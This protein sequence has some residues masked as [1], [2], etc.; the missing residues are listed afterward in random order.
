MPANPT[1][2]EKANVDLAS[3]LKPLLGDAFQVDAETS[4]RADRKLPDI[5]ITYKRSGLQIVLEAKYD[6]FDEAVKAAQKRWHELS[7]P[8][9]VVGAVSYSPS[10]KKNGFESAVRNGDSIDFALSGEQYQDMHALKRRGEIY[11]LAHA[12]RRPY[13]V[14]SRD[15]DAVEKAVDNIKGALAVFVGGVKNN[16]GQAMELA[17]ILQASFNGEKE[18]EVLEQSAKMAGLIL[19]G[20]VLFQLALSKEDA[21][22]SAPNVVLEEEGVTGLDAHWDYILNEINYAAIFRIAR[23]ICAQNI[24]VDLVKQLVGVAHEVEH[25]AHDGVDLMGRIYHRLLADAKT[26]GAFYTTIPAATMMAGLVLNTDDWTDTDWSDAESVGKFRIA[27]PAC[28]SGTLLTAAAWQLLDNFSR[29]HF[30]KHG[31]R[32]GGEKRDDPRAHLCRLLLEESIWGYDILETATHLTAATLGMISPQT[33]F[34]KARIYRA[35][36]GETKLGTA[37]GSLEMLK[38]TKPIFRRDVQIESRD[39]SAQD[40]SRDESEPAESGEDD[41]VPPLHVCIMNP[42]FVRGTAGH[43]S[44]AFLPKNEQKS[45]RRLVKNLG[46]EHNF[47]PDG[48][49]PAFIALAC[50]KRM[51][52]EFI[53]KGGR[54]AVILPATAAVGMG[55]AWKLMRKKIEDDFDLEAL[56]VSREQGRVNFSED[57]MLQECILIAR[58]R[59]D[60]EKPQKTAMFVVLHKNPATIDVALATVQ[61]ILRAKQGDESLGDLRFEAASTLM[62]GEGYIGQYARLPWHGKKAWRGLSFANIHLAFAAETFSESGNLAPFVARGSVPLV[63]LQEIATVGSNRMHKYTKDPDVKKRYVRLSKTVTD[64]PGYYPGHHRGKP[65]FGKK[66]CRKFPNHR[67]ATGCR[68]R[69]KS[70]GRR[71]S[72]HRPGESCCVKVSAF[73]QCAA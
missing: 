40:G 63:P 41:S 45:V 57:T 72:L 68:C 50:L 38:R 20:A 27:D 2:E 9:S 59:N 70:S 34:K 47:V 61:A 31:G 32:I 1:R 5:V 54:L 25:L 17:K 10:F 24:P 71:V 7:P 37:A 21:R 11:D 60:G 30:R 3:C 4:G 39:D 46:I 28:G 6:D 22:V 55:K 23:Q 58:K 14:L 16:H 8:P 13:A 36:I 52:T 15:D 35:I 56:I 65:V 12:L 48:Q 42:P 73:P 62:H 18:K 53:Q 64:Y 51:E 66:T 43:E 29:A 19:F 49:G 33:N 67:N 26:L 69:E 44:F